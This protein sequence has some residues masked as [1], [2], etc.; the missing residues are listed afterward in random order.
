MTKNTDLDYVPGRN[1]MNLVHSSKNGTFPL[2]EIRIWD[3]N[4]YCIVHRFL[5]QFKIMTIK[6]DLKRQFGSIDIYIFDQLLKGRFDN[7]SRLLEVGCGTGRNLVFFLRN[8]FDVHGLEPDSKAVARVRQIAAEL[9]PQL[10]SGNFRIGK[11]EEVHY[12]PCSFDVVIANAVLHFAPDETRF[13]R[14]LHAMWQMLEPGGL[15]FARLA[16]TT[17]CEDIVNRIDGKQH[18][19]PKGEERFLVDHDM[20]IQITTELGGELLEPLKTTRVANERCMTTWVVKKN[21]R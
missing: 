16:S 7:C 2:W 14:M 13:M 20:L 11:V 15:F 8:G 5:L 12:P 17:G 3:L 21:S 1:D 6:D 18:R 9:A 19:L 10:P 4:L